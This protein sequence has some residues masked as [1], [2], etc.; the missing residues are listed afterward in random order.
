M[1]RRCCLLLLVALPSLAWAQVDESFADG[2]FTNTPPWVG[3][4][5]AWQIVAF[6]D[7]FA[8]RTAGERLSDTLFLSTPSAV[9]YG[10]W[11]MTVRYEGGRLSNFN[12]I[13]LYLLADTT[14]LEADVHGYYLQLGTNDRDLR[15]YRSDP[16]VAGGR[17]ELARSQEDLLLAE[18]TTLSITVE[19]SQANVWALYLGETLVFEIPEPDAVFTTSR[20]FGL[21]VKHSSARPEGY[22]FDEVSVTGDTGPRDITPPE[23]A[24]V[25]YEAL[26]PG[27]EAAFTEPIAT[28]TLADAFTLSQAGTPVPLASVTPVDDS[29]AVVRLDTPLPTGVFSFAIT[30]VGDRAGNLL[31]DTTLTISVEADVT[32]PEIVAVSA[33]DSLLLEVRLSEPVPA[34]CTA[35]SL[36]VS[37]GI[38][39]PVS[40][41]LDGDGDAATLRFGTPFD[42]GQTYTFTARHL[43]DRFGNVQAEASLPFTYLVFPDAAPPPL[44]LVLNEIYYDPPESELE[45]VEVYNRSAA[46]Y[47]IRHL[48]LSDNRLQP[49]P[50]ADSTR[51]LLP[52]GYLVLARDSLAFATAFPDQPFLPI[53]NWPSLNNTGDAVVLFFDD[54]VI[55]SVAYSPSWGGDGVSLERKDPGGPSLLRSN[56]GSSTALAGASPGLE[57]SL[58]AIDTTP[59]LPLRVQPDVDGDTLLVTFSEPLDPASV[60]P[61]DFLIASLNRVPTTATVA[62]TLVT[63]AFSESLTRGDY[64]LVVRNVAD[65]RGN[66]TTEA[67]IS[68]SF[69]VPDVPIPGDVVLNEL[70]YDPPADDLE[71]VELFNRSPRTFDLQTWSLADANRTPRALAKQQTP[72]E[73][74]DYV[75]LVRDADAF[76]AAFPGVAALAVPNWPSLNNSGDTVLLLAEGGVIDSVAYAP[77]WGG[78]GVSLERIDPDGPSDTRFNW[79]SARAEGGA[80]PGTVNSIF[81]S[82]AD[83]PQLI[84]AEQHT[85]TVLDAYFDE[86]LASASVPTAQWQVGPD[87]PQQAVLETDTRVRLTFAAPFS[88]ETL[89]VSG[90]RDLKGNLRPSTSAGVAWQASPSALILNEILFDP[91]RSPTDGAPDQPEYLELFNASGRLL[92][93]RGLLLADAPDE[94][95]TADTLHIPA[96]L[97][98]LA[99]GQ[100]A[101]IFAQP[102][103]VPDLASGSELALAFQTTFDT[104]TTPLLP[105]FRSSLGLGNEADRVRL[106]RADGML[107]DA[108]T[109][110]SSWQ[111]A[112]LAD[113]T[114]FALERLRTD[115]PTDDPLTWATSQDPLGGTPGRPNA[116]HAPEGGRPPE[117]GELLLTEILFDPLQDENDARADQSEF[118]ELFNHTTDS[119][120][121]NGLFWTDR[122]DENDVADTTRIVYLPNLLPPGHYAV[123]FA[124]PSTVPDANLPFLLR[125]AFPSLPSPS[126]LFPLR[127]ASLGLTNE[128]GR[129]RLH[130]AD[131]VVLEGVDYADDWHHPNLSATKG[132][133]LERV[134][135][136]G[137]SSDASN[138]T[139]SPALA[140]GTPGAPNAI[141][142]QPPPE[143]AQPGLTITPS[144]FSPDRDGF[145]D[146][147]QI[148][149][150]L[151]ETG[152]LLRVRIFDSRGR[153]V[154]TLTPAQITARSGV[155]VWDGLGDRQQKLRLGIYIVHAEA[156]HPDKGTTEAYQTPV[157]LA[158]PL[159]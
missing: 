1:G 2:D 65:F 35:A 46:P 61:S 135:L 131:G 134:A 22:L 10:R 125:A 19:R 13:R 85:E 127:G 84:F 29:I 123:V 97:Q 156:V 38:G 100:F 157:V 33:L 130:R 139:S 67:T 71:F 49:V 105:L 126:P 133:S 115:A 152:G 89:V 24:A 56:W 54:Q 154:R 5:A 16:R 121:L 113:A 147:T 122:P 86:P 137:R 64:T 136:A 140:G 150:T 26:L 51:A 88:G 106:H 128:A 77:A 42:N 72:L 151:R 75:V 92:S 120:R 27:F 110:A 111:D 36:E 31:A 58:F 119:L 104:R 53:A 4:V 57:N 37:G 69:F 17:T 141:S 78:D 74:G 109:Y 107:L 146:V 55:D 7:D 118:F 158:Y 48:R 62:D 79:A 142:V 90:I 41:T 18:D 11:A 148:Q 6:G 153:L 96:G 60:A 66:A 129:I 28:A 155:L 145:E 95:G 9:S 99:A 114:G 15:L 83:A 108:V 40:C 30:G 8:L 149:Y 70:F 102:E 68:F 117:P 76:S 45:F 91:R 63:L 80:T 52:G 3:D 103:P 124:A 47:D 81:A 21:W 12:L 116:T 132:V 50:V 143:R 94:E 82:D 44:T 159:D 25:R 23:V 34:L 101:V 32:P 73:P 59:P 43:E 20:H 138:W 93:L 144:P 98:A 87:A 39:P 112:A 14:A